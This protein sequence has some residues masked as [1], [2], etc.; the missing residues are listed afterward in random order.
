MADGEWRVG[1]VGRQHEDRAGT[2]VEYPGRPAM[3]PRGHVRML[4]SRF[5]KK[6]FELRCHE[7]K[8]AYLFR[9]PQD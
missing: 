7:C 4:P 6:E 2:E 9:E 3:C 8:R 1:A 5:S